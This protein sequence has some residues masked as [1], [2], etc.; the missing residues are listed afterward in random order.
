MLDRGILTQKF[1]NASIM[2][3]I[4]VNNKS[5]V[6]NDWDCLYKESMP[7]FKIQNEI[8]KIGDFINESYYCEILKEKFSCIL[9]DIG[10]YTAISYVSGSDAIFNSVI[11]SKRLKE[12][13]TLFIYKNSFHGRYVEL[14]KENILTLNDLR[15]HQISFERNRQVLLKTID[16]LRK[17][18]RQ[19]VLI[20][21]FFGDSF[22]I[23]SND[24]F[25]KL[26]RVCNEQE[27]ILIFDEVR[28]GVFKTGDFTLSQFLRISPDIICVSKGLSVGLPIAITLYKK[29]L[30]NCIIDE[31]TNSLRGFFCKNINSL[32][33]AI[34]N[35]NY[36]IQERPRLIK[37]FKELNLAAHKELEF[38]Y[39]YP[40]IDYIQIQGLYFIITF[41]EN[42]VLTELQKIL[43]VK[44]M[45]AEGIYCDPPEN[46]GAWVFLFSL[47]VSL[48]NILLLKNKLQS[49]F[50]TF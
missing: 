2:K 41:K 12:S 29:Y 18:K 21:P 40:F 47:D 28:T 36:F 42:F 17:A 25:E 11:W 24:F 27:H 33:R 34:A 1:L 50:D 15:V 14:I 46:T 32:K 4:N 45:Q 20:E 10:D 44:K 13:N 38:L 37:K 5:L 31:I 3:F 30:F 7:H 9:T 48:N 39:S 16:I 8:G 49:I 35:I 26:I 6:L 43:L 22:Y 23:S 19:I